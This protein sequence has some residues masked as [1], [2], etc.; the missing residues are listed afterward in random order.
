MTLQLRG[1]ALRSAY[2]KLHSLLIQGWTDEEIAEEIG[3][4]FSDYEILKTKFFDKQSEITREK[5]TEHTYVQYMIEQ[6]A[7]IADLDNLIAEYDT[8]KNQSAYVGAIKA[9]SD[10]LDKIIKM[11]QELGLV[12]R[13]SDSGRLVAGQ[14]I[15]N[16]TN[17]ELKQFVLGEIQAVNEMHLRYGDQSIDQIDSGPIY[18]PLPKAPISKLDT[19]NKTKRKPPSKNSGG[20]RVV[21]SKV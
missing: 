1:K 7:C 19:G 17:V 16:L 13:N 18:K 9:K 20:R 21:R 6:K 15:V 12:E 3:I 14:A 4:Q 10:I 8:S 11:G 2:A 5:T